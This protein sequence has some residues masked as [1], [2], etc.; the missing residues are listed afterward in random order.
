M[1]A[2]ESGNRDIL[3]SFWIFYKLK[4]EWVVRVRLWKEWVLSCVANFLYVCFDCLYYMM[5]SCDTLHIRLSFHPFLA[6][7]AYVSGQSLRLCVKVSERKMPWD[8]GPL[9]NW[10]TCPYN[11]QLIIKKNRIKST[12][13]VFPVEIGQTANTKAQVLQ[14]QSTFLLWLTWVV[15]FCLEKE[16]K[17][18]EE[19]NERGRERERRLR[20]TET[21]TFFFFWEVIRYRLVQVDPKN[22]HKKS[23]FHK[24]YNQVPFHR[25]VKKKKF[26]S[27][28]M[29]S[30]SRKST[31]PNRVALKGCSASQ[32]F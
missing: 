21:K 18:D 24:N 30:V 6:N 4:A 25:A 11:L 15:D 3:W 20:A 14:D 22:S 28:G 26:V 8:R 23:P 10:L 7:F 29:N 32:D 1:R 12:S 9:T 5:L 16:G 13:L 31:Y 17:L 2:W 27:K 19:S